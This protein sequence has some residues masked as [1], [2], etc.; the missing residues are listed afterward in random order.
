[1]VRDQERQKEKKLSSEN[2]LKTTMKNK[3]WIWQEVL[4]E[5]HVT[6]PLP[7]AWLLEQM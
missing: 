7:S 6:K 1:M 4:L 5:S 2:M 3:N